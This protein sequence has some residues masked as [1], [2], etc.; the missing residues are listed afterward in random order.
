MELFNEISWVDVFLCSTAIL[1]IITG[2]IRGLVRTIVTIISWVFGF[3][4]AYTFAPN[5]TVYLDNY[6]EDIDIKLWSIQFIIFAFVVIC[7]A[8]IGNLT[9]KIID[10]SGVKNIDRVSG[11]VLGFVLSVIIVSII[12]LASNLTSFPQSKHYQMSSLIPHLIEPAEF[13]KTY[14]PEEWQE[15]I[16]LDR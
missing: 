15:Q 8:V 1:V 4:L 6:I 13:I 11:L 10:F 12:V 2:A 14:F 7:G 3:Y 5:Y 9:S 16:K